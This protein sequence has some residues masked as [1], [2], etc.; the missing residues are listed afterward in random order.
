MRDTKQ[1]TDF[2]DFLK[3]DFEIEIGPEYPVIDQVESHRPAVNSLSLIAAN[4][5]IED[6]QSCT[7]ALNL[8]SEVK[9]KYKELE[10]FRKKTIEPSRKFVQMV[11]DCVKSLHEQLNR[12]EMEVKFKM[13]VYQK[14]EEERT[15]LAEQSIR[16]L[17]ESLGVEIA[18]PSAPKMESANASVYYKTTTSFE[19]VDE[20]LIPA[21]Y[22]MVDREAIQNDIDMGLEIPG[23]KVTK[24]RKMH[25]RRR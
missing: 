13:S 1:S 18:V 19:I 9:K 15:R 23:V 7:K 11:N 24:E 8:T 21:N 12:I 3:D 16:Q 22:W 5:A 17:S 14:I 2:L 10:D 25:I 4:L 20:K 6:M